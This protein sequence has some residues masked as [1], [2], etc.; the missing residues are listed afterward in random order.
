MTRIVQRLSFA[1]A[2]RI[3]PMAA[4]LTTLLCGCVSQKQHRKDMP[5]CCLGFTNENPAACVEKTTNYTLGVVE[6]DDQGWFWDRQQMD[7]VLKWINT[8][9]LRTITPACWFAF[10]C[11]AG[12]TTRSSTMIT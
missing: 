9:T 2:I 5:E 12:S 3:L 7:C 10:S 6:I 1:S 4:V 11:M 8:R